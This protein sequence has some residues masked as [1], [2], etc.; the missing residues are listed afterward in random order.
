M[1]VSDEDLI[2]YLFDLHDPDERAALRA[3][4]AA[5]P[6]LAA[7]LNALRDTVAP[8]V[9][10]RADEPVPPPGLATRALAAVAGYVVEHEPRPVPATPAEVRKRTYGTDPATDLEPVDDLPPGFLEQYAP[11]AASAAPPAVLAE[12]RRAPA[13]ADGPEF[14]GRRV[15]AELLV[16]VSIA[17]VSLALLASGIS[18]ARQRQNEVLCQ[19]GLRTLHTGLAS[20]A[21]ADPRG[22]YPQVGTDVPTA[23]SFPAALAAQHLPAGFKAACPVSTDCRA[24][25]YTL[26]FRDGGDVLGLRRPTATE[27][28]GEFDLMPIAAD[29]PAAGFAPT[30]FPVSPHGACMNVLFVGGNVRATTS[31]LI[32]PN[33]DDIYCNARGAIAAGLTRTDAVLGG[34]GTRP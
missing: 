3:R 12:P 21:D 29:L 9:A 11:P 8:L 17:F 19:N 14:R 26:G 10:E 4:L 20:Y 22:R 13:P 34:P 32:G 23:D 24:Y 33:G 28:P 15:R 16:A 30:G 5:D 27:T 1:T 7:R 25:A 31:P 18:K 2:G 6:A